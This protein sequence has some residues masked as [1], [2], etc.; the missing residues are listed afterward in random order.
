[1]IFSRQK[2]AS[3]GCATGEDDPLDAG[4]RPQK[5]LTATKLK[6]LDNHAL[7]KKTILKKL[8]C[9]DVTPKDKLYHSL[10]LS[11]TKDKLEE[12]STFDVIRMLVSN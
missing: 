10:L 1:M 7:K 4:H 9:N 3:R 6:K 12:Y 8:T 11:N 5:T 2:E